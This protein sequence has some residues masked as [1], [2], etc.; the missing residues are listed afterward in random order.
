MLLRFC[1][2]LAEKAV[3]VLDNERTEN[4]GILLRYP[5]LIFAG[6]K[7]YGKLRLPTALIY[8]PACFSSFISTLFDLKRPL[9]DPSLYA[10]DTIRH[11]LDF[12]NSRFA[13]MDESLENRSWFTRSEALDELKREL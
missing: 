10:L 8:L 6:K 3:N 2:K 12:S 9:F 13:G 7:N 4:W 5:G 11:N 1:R